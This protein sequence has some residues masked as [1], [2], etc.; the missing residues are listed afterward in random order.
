MSMSGCQVQDPH[1][2]P[3]QQKPLSSNSGYLGNSTEDKY[4]EDEEEDEDTEEDCDKDDEP[5]AID[6]PFLV[7]YNILI[8][9]KK[10]SAKLAAG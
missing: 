3:I 5:T 8:G 7:F 10:T 9:K 4:E 6:K 2:A 1:G